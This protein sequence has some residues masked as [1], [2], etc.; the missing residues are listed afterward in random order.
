M[1]GSIAHNW[2][3]SLLN[4]QVNASCGNT[5]FLGKRSPKVLIIRFR[6]FERRWIQLNIQ[7]ANERFGL[8]LKF[9]ALNLGALRR[10]QRLRGNVYFYVA[11]RK[12]PACQAVILFHLVF[13]KR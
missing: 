7:A 2:G 10:R 12:T 5:I 6:F 11:S 1:P 9:Q 13:R 3:Q 4:L 8:N